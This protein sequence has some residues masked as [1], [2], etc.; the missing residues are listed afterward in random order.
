MSYLLLFDAHNTCGKGIL[1]FNT[2]L[3]PQIIFIFIANSTSPTLH[4]IYVVKHAIVN[5]VKVF[6]DMICI[7][8]QYFPTF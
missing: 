6:L 1:A 5:V 2:H 3:V 8:P 7:L 4:N